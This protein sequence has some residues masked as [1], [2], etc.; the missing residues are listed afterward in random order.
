MATQLD[1]TATRNDIFRN[2]YWNSGIVP[3]GE[4][5][6]ADQIKI[7]KF[8]L[9]SIVKN[10]EASIQ[11]LWAYRDVPIN[12]IVGPPPTYI[13]PEADAVGIDSAW[14]T[15]NNLTTTIDIYSREHYYSLEDRF[16][17]T[18]RPQGVYFERDVNASRLH[19]YPIPDAIYAMT[20][21]LSIRLRDFDVPDDNIAGDLWP[22]SW[23]EPLTWKLTANLSHVFRLPLK[24]R[25]LYEKKADDLLK[26]VKVDS[27]SENDRGEVKFEAE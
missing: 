5:P 9:N 18:G 16:V 23:I 25:V 24:E 14:V 12:T 13:I 6:D 22:Q 3:Y 7:A 4:E 27:F 20:Y 2:A 17:T 8:H 1:W 15:E 19:I 26:S 10:L 11:P 21:R